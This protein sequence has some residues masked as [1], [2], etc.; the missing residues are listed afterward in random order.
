MLRHIVTNRGFYLISIPIFL[1]L[2]VSYF[3]GKSIK[4]VS[5][6]DHDVYWLCTDLPEFTVPGTTISVHT[7]KDGEVMNT[8]CHGMDKDFFQV[9]EKVADGWVRDS[10]PQEKKALGFMRW[11]DMDLSSDL[12]YR[13]R[14][15]AFM[16]NFVLVTI[17]AKNQQD[18]ID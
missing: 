18:I 7:P 10:D 13:I 5:Q 11:L 1:F 9:I 6:G 17:V 14:S 8:A 3:G 4:S 16:P 15:T 12:S 2:G